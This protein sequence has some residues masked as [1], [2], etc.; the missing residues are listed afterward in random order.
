MPTYVMEHN[1]SLFVSTNRS[2]LL[3]V[4]VIRKISIFISR[5]LKFIYQGSLKCDFE[6]EVIM[7]IYGSGQ[8]ETWIYSPFC[9]SFRQEFLATQKPQYKS[10]LLVLMYSSNGMPLSARVRN[11][12]PT[13][14]TERMS[15]EKYA[16]ENSKISLS[17]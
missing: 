8:A 17:R 5:I 6:N 15:I 11:S 9:F 13:A 7:N 14:K 1:I 16:K 2:W 12:H 3:Q 10:F 4:E